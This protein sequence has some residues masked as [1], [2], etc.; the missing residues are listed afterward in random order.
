MTTIVPAAPEELQDVLTLLFQRL[1]EEERQDRLARAMSMVARGE[2]TAG[3]ILLA[4]SDQGPPCGAM[5]CQPLAGACALLWP[6][7]VPVGPQCRAIE[8]QLVQNCLHRLRQGGTKLV[9]AILGPTDLL[10]AESLERNGIQQITQ[11]AYL[12]HP[13]GQQPQLRSQPR[14]RFQNHPENNWPLLAQILEKTYQG[15]LDCPEL[16]G[17]RAM[18][19]VLAGHRGQGVYRPDWWWL[20]FL[21]DQPVGVLFLTESPNQE[22]VDLSYIGVVPQARRQGIGRQLVQLALQTAQEA[23]A[24]QLTLALDVRNHPARNLYEELGFEQIGLR[25]VYLCFLTAPGVS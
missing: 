16:N 1:P 11:V 7:Q 10:L 8:D 9:Q 25:E 12:R 19:E 22:G 5:I 4:R 3:Q 17:V 24:W 15:T 18:E 13:L 14:L 21:D 20:A 6:P 23:G 2:L